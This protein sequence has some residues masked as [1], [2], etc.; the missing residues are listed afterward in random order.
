MKLRLEQLASSLKKGLAPVYVISG[1]EPLQAGEA[2]DQVRAAAKQAGY[3]S[4]EIMEADA[5]FDWNRL[6]EEANALSLFAEQKIIDL[7]LPSGKPGAAGAKA[8]VEYCTNLPADTLLLLT[9]PKVPLTSKWIKALEKTGVLVQV[10][11]VDERNLPR[12]ISGRMQAAGLRPEKGVAEMLAEHT[13][14]NLLAARQEIEKLV[15]LYGEG[16][17]SQEQLLEA[18]SDSARFDVY[19]LVDAAL[20]GRKAR[21]T[22]ILSGLKGEGIAPPVVLWALAREIRSLANMAAH[23]AGGM[24]V[25]Q[26]MNQA[27]VWKTRVPLVSQGL[28]RLKPGAWSRL[29]QQCADIDATIKGA[30]S[31]DAW[32]MLEQVALAMAGAETVQGLWSSRK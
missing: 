29:L 2:A 11:P 20:A 21:C 17:I 13:E 6:G 24:P 23:M 9:L 1:D 12:W 10:W 30:G 25:S 16:G 26:A 14:G 32:L 7:R 28:K 3:L 19:A 27:R 18:V 4:R 22:H 8:L 15:L 31:G 5:R